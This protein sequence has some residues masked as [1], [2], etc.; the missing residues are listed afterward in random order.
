MHFTTAVILIVMPLSGQHLRNAHFFYNQK[1][2]YAIGTAKTITLHVG[3]LGY[4][5][6]LRHHDSRKKSI[7]VLMTL[8]IV[9]LYIT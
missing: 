5:Q 3:Q 4:G 7:L 8:L 1:V 2:L 9:I 6:H